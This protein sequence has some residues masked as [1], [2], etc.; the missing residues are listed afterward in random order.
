[1]GLGLDPEGW[2]E[3]DD[4]EEERTKADSDGHASSATSYQK[5]SIKGWS[6]G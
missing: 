2:V 3:L 4:E 5:V 1:M 6:E